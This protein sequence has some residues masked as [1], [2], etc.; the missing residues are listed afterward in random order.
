MP[1]RPTFG[2]RRAALTTLAHAGRTATALAVVLALAAPLAAAPT[3]HPAPRK[4][5]PAAQPLPTVTTSLWHKAQDVAIFALGLIGV[6]YRF[7]GDD[8]Q[9]GVD[10]SGLVRY[11]FQQTTG[12]TLPR[13]SAQLGKLGA[14]VG[15]SD[16]LPGDLVFFNTR[17]FMNSHVGIYLGDNRFVHAP[18]TGSEVEISSLDEAYWRQHFNGARRLIGVLP[19]LI[20]TAMAAEPAAAFGFGEPLGTPSVGTLGPLPA[21][22]AIAAMAPAPVLQPLA[23]DP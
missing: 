11:V 21:P 22:A 18:S 7:G 10:C 15:R 4:A 17:R 14:Q 19:N 8:P 6:D 1:S 5:A 20:P 23:F 2:A 12:I 3:K 9:T 13:T 16:L